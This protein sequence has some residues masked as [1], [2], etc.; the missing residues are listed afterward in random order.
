MVQPTQEPCSC[1]GPRPAG[2]TQVFRR[3]MTHS[4]IK[5]PKVI[6]HAGERR[7]IDFEVTRIL[8]AVWCTPEPCSC[9]GPRP[10]SRTQ[11]FGSSARRQMAHSIIKPPKVIFHAGEPRD[12]DFEVTRILRAVWCT[13]EPC[14]C[15]G[16]RPASRT[17]VFGSCA[18]P[19]N[20]P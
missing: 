9:V 13:P 5:P 12:I 20:D 8:R 11:V 17:Q 19:P 16:P 7:D 6:F 1:G 3:Q 4:I 18:P 2:R 14:S 10:A 15:G